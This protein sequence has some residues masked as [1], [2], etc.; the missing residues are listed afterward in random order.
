MTDATTIPPPGS[1]VI[2]DEDLLVFIDETGH[3]VISDDKSI[4]G[5][6]GIIVYGAD[7]HKNIEVP[8]GK[9]RET[10]GL[11]NDQPLHAASDFDIYKNHL[12]AL[13]NFFISG[14]FVRHISII[15]PK[16]TSNFDPFITATCAGMA[17]NVG[18]TLARVCGNSAV[19]RIVYIVEHSERLHSTYEKLVTPAG[20]TLE[21]LDGTKKTFPHQWATLRKSSCTAGLE[22][23]DF[24]LHAAQGQVRA[25]LKNANAPYRKD[26]KAVF[27]DVHT[28]YVEYMRIDDAQATPAD[29]PPGMFRIG[30]NST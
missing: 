15:T 20:P 29:G 19:N 30:L 18:R 12:E 10:I 9:L 11:A 4:F 17:R 13:S 23:A 28:D 16:T 26:F 3:E 7:Y 5:T 2:N 21:S 25:E 24:V 8:W 27:R 1:L 6:G 22:I 14:F